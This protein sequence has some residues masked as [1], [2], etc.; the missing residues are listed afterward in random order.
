MGT[1]VTKEAPDFRAQAVLADGTIGELS[2]AAYRGKT[3]VLVL[4][5]TRLHLR[6]PVR[7]PGV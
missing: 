1:L 6:L 7:N 4:L 2:L 3:V 5:S